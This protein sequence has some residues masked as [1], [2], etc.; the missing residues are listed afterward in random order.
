MPH[1]QAKSRRGFEDFP[2]G[3]VARMLH[4]VSTSPEQRTAIFPFLRCRPELPARL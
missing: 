4:K 2:V 3:C 1:L